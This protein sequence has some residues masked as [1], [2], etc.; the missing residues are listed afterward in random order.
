MR[1]G[2][3]EF[4]FGAKPILL[5]GESADLNL[6]NFLDLNWDEARMYFSKQSQFS[7]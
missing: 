3:P 7:E 4:M 5:E 6:Y 2:E 1:Q